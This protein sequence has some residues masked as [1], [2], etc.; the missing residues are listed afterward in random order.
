MIDLAILQLSDGAW[1]Y[2]REDV[3]LAHP[4]SNQLSV[5]GAEIEDENLVEVPGRRVPGG[6]DHELA[7]PHLLRLLQC[8]A[9]GLQGGSGRAVGCG[10]AVPP[11]AHVLDTQ[12][13]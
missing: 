7:H 13:A 3:C 12:R 10:T 9:F 1:H 11:V 2:L 4:A 6:A 8:L 5:L